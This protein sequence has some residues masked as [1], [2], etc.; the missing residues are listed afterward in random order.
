MWELWV[1]RCEEPVQGGQV[2]QSEVVFK[3]Y[4]RGEG[5]IPWC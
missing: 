3:I 1:L 2:L 5:L 4:P